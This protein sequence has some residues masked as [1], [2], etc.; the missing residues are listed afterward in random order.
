MR[1]LWGFVA[2]GVFNMFKC[3]QILGFVAM[4]CN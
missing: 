4:I 1:K 3:L 2:H